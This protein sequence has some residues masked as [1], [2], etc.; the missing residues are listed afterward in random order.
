MSL[1]MLDAHKILDDMVDPNVESVMDSY[2]SRAKAGFDKYG[3][4]TTRTDIDLMGWLT[5]LQEELMDATIY[6]ERLKKEI[7]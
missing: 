2:R 4:D 1:T 5:H 3:T 7:V 6:I